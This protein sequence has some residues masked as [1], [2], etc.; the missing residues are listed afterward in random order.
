MFLCLSVAMPRLAAAEAVMSPQARLVVAEQYQMQGRRGEALRELE[1]LSVEMPAD[2]GGVLALAIEGA[3]GKSYLLAGEKG[4]ARSR[5]EAAL[6]GARAQHL[7]AL[8]SALLNDLGLL[9]LA[10]DKPA[11]ALIVFENARHAAKSAVQPLLFSRA[12]INAIQAMISAGRPERVEAWLSEARVHLGQSPDS[13]EKVFLLI[14][15]ANQYRRRMEGTPAREVAFRSLYEAA[16]IASSLRDSRA[17]SFALGYLGE[18]YAAARR[19]DDALR[20][21]RRALFL[22]QL[23]ESH[24]ALFRWHWQIGR[25]EARAERSDEAM[26]AYERAIASLQVLRADLMSD[27]RAIG[28]SWRDTVGPLYLEYADLLLRRAASV[29]MSQSKSWLEKARN[30]VEQLKT[31]EL[32][33][34]F[35]DEC[36]ASSQ[37]KKMTFDDPGPGTAVLY[38]ILLP[39]RVEM[40]ISLSGDIRQVRLDIDGSRLGEEVLGLRRLLE[41]RTTHQYLPH[42]KALYTRLIGP[43]EGLI[44]AAGIHTLVFIPDGPLRG[45]PL[46]ALHDGKQFLVEL[47]AIA[48][49]PG[50]SLV[51]S[52]AGREGRRTSTLSGGITESVQSFP[53]LPYVEPEMQVVQS[54]YGGKTLKDAQFLIPRFEQELRQ[55]SFSMVHIASHGQIESDPRKSFLLAYDG[56]ITMDNLEGYLK[57]SRMREE[58]VDLLTLSACRTAAGDDRAALGLAGMAVKAGARS[59]LATLWYVND[60]ASS[61]L[62]TEFYREMSTGKVGKAEALREAQRKVLADPRYRHPGYWAPFLLIGNWQ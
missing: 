56:K 33:D 53:A 24:D 29:P 2:K 57:F 60:Q 50:L 11:E 13:T 30:S 58:S 42:A 38:P 62:I 37:S 61:M 6:T 36:V 52:V 16:R 27:L 40:L 17:E 9:E 35:Q 34:Y 12:T 5:L 48:V 20:L 51:E 23:D 14:E 1:A 19:E 43:I 15:L 22:A 54:L 31:V 32:E 39:D 28:A 21:I 41:K 26:A 59:A 46:A 18:L 49:A 7:F 4:P 25:M 10:E 44:T 3:L 8:E 55:T 47:Y 45:L